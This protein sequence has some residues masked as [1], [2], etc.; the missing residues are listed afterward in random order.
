M[1]A[2]AD[3][4]DGDLS[5]AEHLRLNPV[6][7]SASPAELRFRRR[8]L[9]VYRRSPAWPGKDRALAFELFHY[10]RRLVIAAHMLDVAAPPLA[11]RSKYAPE[12]RAA[13]EDRLAQAGLDVHAPDPGTGDAF[14]DG[15]LVI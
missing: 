15:D 7:S 1:E 13:L 2:V 12:A 8:R 9:A 14:E 10:D 3:E 5:E 4:Q 6:S 11:E